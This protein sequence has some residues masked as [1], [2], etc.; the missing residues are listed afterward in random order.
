M[1]VMKQVLKNRTVNSESGV[2]LLFSGASVL[3]EFNRAKVLE[4]QG[5][6]VLKC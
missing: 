2:S 1:S 4:Q 3:I 5:V 6:I